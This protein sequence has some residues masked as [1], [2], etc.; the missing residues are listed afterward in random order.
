MR[1]NRKPVVKKTPVKV[2]VPVTIL[3]EFPSFPITN[4]IS[5]PQQKLR[6]Y[7]PPEPP[8]M[9][10]GEHFDEMRRKQKELELKVSTMRLISTVVTKTIIQN[11]DIVTRRKVSMIK[12]FPDTVI[13][14]KAIM[15]TYEEIVTVQPYLTPDQ[16]LQQIAD[17]LIKEA[18]QR[19][20]RHRLEEEET[21]LKEQREFNEKH[22]IW[23]KCGTYVADPD[24]RHTCFNCNQDYQINLKYV[25]YNVDGC[26]RCNKAENVAKNMC[27]SRN[28]TF[29][30]IRKSDKD[31][32]QGTCTQGEMKVTFQC[33][34]LKHECTMNLSSLRR[35][36]NCKTCTRMKLSRMYK[37]RNQGIKVVRKVCPCFGKYKNK[38]TGLSSKP[39]VCPHH[40]HKECGNGS[41]DEWDYDLNYPVRPEDIAPCAIIERWFRCSNSY[42][43]MPYKQSPSVRVL[44]GS[45]C[46]F[47]TGQRVCYWNSLL[48]RRP[49][50]CKELSKYNT[51]PPD[52]VTIGSK[53]KL[54]WCCKKHPDQ[55]EPFV[56]FASP[57]QRVTG[58][59][60][61]PK[62][63]KAGYEQMKQGHD[64][65]VR[66]ARLVHGDNY[67][68]PETYI[69]SKDKIA[70]KCERNK[71][72]G[73]FSVT[74]NN[75]K[76]G[77]GCPRCADEQTESKGMTELKAILNNILL[78]C[79][80]TYDVEKIFPGLKYKRSL[81]FDIYIPYFNLCIEYD[82][83]QHF[84]PTSWCDK[85]ALKENHLR[86]RL[87]DSFCVL[88]KMSL[89]RIPYT[90]KPTQDMIMFLITKITDDKFVPNRK[91][92]YASY[93]HYQK[94][95]L[96]Q[97]VNIDGMILEEITAPKTT[98]TTTMSTTEIEQPKSRKFK[99]SN[100]NSTPDG[101]ANPIIIPGSLSDIDPNSLAG[102]LR[103]ENAHK[104]K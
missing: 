2:N 51:I 80:L 65:F 85:D 98:D 61:C 71:K 17:D 32:R 81:K 41:A 3:A 47:C 56:W 92:V 75:H 19:I 77:S 27:E 87:K 64:E 89:L 24:S 48:T 18:E 36:S 84:V 33:P 38:K 14:T 97:I 42:C 20:I 49:E 72:H 94:H 58:K 90:V 44:S 30:S 102:L 67:S 60:G 91:F 68:Y 15:E 55:K 25:F 31:Q 88:N 22:G 10:L 78:P 79:N 70:V 29:I 11:V 86:D 21:K 93:N 45:R 69:G 16:W 5:V 104:N 57:L 62:C 43:K 63:N 1:S 8:L 74:P 26:L 99:E 59:S 82:G 35:G 50:L 37:K 6:P 66:E 34:I 52:T 100:K 76:R 9:H 96:A 103:R 28:F 13:V 54:L 101:F 46:L 4:W 73:I 7:L 12:E 83:E 53:V 23:I 39:T 40:N 95:V